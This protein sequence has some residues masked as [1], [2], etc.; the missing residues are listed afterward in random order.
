M[1]RIELREATIRIKDGLSGTGAVNE[2]TPASAATD[3]DV[4]TLVL[5]TDDTD[6]VPVGARFTIAGETGSPVHTVTARP[7]RQALVALYGNSPRSWRVFAKTLY[8]TY[9]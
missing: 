9:V 7:S 4:D 6:L 8:Y 3:L 5:N 2:M 1:A